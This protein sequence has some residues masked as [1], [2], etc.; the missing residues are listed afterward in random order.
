LAQNDRVQLQLCGGRRVGDQNG[1]LA[2]ADVDP[3]DLGGELRRQGSDAVP[4]QFGEVQGFLDHGP[5]AGVLD[6][7]AVE[8]RRVLQCGSEQGRG[9]CRLS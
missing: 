6:E 8:S 5:K 4:R 7:D 9:Q 1:E 3:A 2:V